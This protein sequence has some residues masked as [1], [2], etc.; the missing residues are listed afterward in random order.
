MEARSMFAIAM[1]SGF[2]WFGMGLMWLWMLVPLALVIGV[3]W[4]FAKAAAGHEA[5]R[6]GGEAATLRRRLAAGEIDVEQYEQARV[7]L[8]LSE[9]TNE[10]R[11]S[12]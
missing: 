12:Q 3:V 6:G 5:A 10:V 11:S 7:A 9:G 4:L 1:M 2:G 8:G